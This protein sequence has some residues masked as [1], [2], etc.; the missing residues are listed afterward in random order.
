[1]IRKLIPERVVQAIRRH[2]GAPELGQS[3]RNLRR[4]G[5]R[6][7]MAVDVGA[8]VGEWTQEARAIFPEM[9]VLM[10]EPQ[11]EK[12]NGLERLA[13]ASGGAVQF[14]PVLLG[15]QDTDRH[16]FYVNETVSSVL[17]EHYETDAQKIEMPMRRL[18][19]VLAERQ[20]PPPN[21]IKLDTQGF[22][23]EVLRGAVEATSNPALEVV[24]MEVSLIDV[25]VGAP[26]V[27][28]VVAFMSNLDFDLYDITSLIRRPTDDALW[29]IDALFARQDSPL[30]S[31]KKWG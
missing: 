3:L 23:L 18:D 6:P 4:N 16:T 25:N 26:L 31:S 13:A 22:E 24:Q 28:D 5:F 27:R 30:T 10:V 9:Q 20:C 8:Y 14:E 15:A 21:L 29:Q 17:P 2:A 19:V 11:A 7:T 1:M 12:A